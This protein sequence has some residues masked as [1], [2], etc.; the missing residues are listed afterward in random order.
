MNVDAR[1][2]IGGILNSILAEENVLHATARDYYWNVTGLEFLHL[3]QHFGVEYKQAERWM[4]EV[5]EHACMIGAGAR[6]S[7]S[8]LAKAASAYAAPGVGLP[9]LDM[10]SE[11]LI[12]HD[13]LVAQL[14]TDRETCARHHTASGTTDFLT[15]LMKQHEKAAWLLRAQLSDRPKRNPLV[16]FNPSLT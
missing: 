8:D 16:S 11:L 7:S 6:G 5:A 4:D 14:R 15:G 1:E 13:L 3:R 9:A 12:L 10:L 2:E